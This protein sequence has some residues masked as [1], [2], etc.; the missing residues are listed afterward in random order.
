MSLKNVTVLINVKKYARFSYQF[1]FLLF[2]LFS[3]QSVLITTIL[4]ST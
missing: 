1:L 4:L 3:L 2:D